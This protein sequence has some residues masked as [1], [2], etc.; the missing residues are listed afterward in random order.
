MKS[1]IFADK[2]PKCTI[3]SCEGGVVKP[4][5]IFFGENLPGKVLIT[6]GIRKFGSAALGLQVNNISHKSNCCAKS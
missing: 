2:V 6:G 4:N 1:E 5:I 3:T